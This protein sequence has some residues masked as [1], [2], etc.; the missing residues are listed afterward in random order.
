M[1]AN[2]LIQLRQLPALATRYADRALKFDA[3]DVQVLWLR[4]TAGNFKL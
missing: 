1:S 2:T 4:D 3:M